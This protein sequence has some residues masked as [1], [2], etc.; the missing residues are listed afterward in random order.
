MANN[1]LRKAVTLIRHANENLARANELLKEV[2]N[3]K[4]WVSPSWLEVGVAW[5]LYKYANELNEDIEI[6]PS[7]DNTMFNASF[8]HDGVIFHELCVPMS[9]HDEYVKRVK[10]DN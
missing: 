4:V 6:T 9:W 5:D 2:Y 8:T 3:N 10:G 1:N 7:E